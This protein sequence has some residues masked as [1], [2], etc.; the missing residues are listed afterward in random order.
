MDFQRRAPRFKLDGVDVIDKDHEM[1]IAHRNRRAGEG[2]SGGFQ[3]H[4]NRGVGSVS[5]HRNFG[6]GEA[7]H[8]HVDPDQPVVEQPRPDDARQRMQR[9]FTMARR[10]AAAVDVLRDA[11][12]GI[13]AHFRLGAVGIVDVHREIGAAERL[14]GHQSVGADAVAAV[15]K[16][17]RQ[18][19]EIAS[20]VE[21]GFHQNKIVAQ[22]VI[23][24]KNHRSDP[25]IFPESCLRN[26]LFSFRQRSMASA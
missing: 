8:A 4:F 19:P 26:Q 2:A 18:G 1:R 16:R 17:H 3:R 20:G 15:A 21:P 25:H 24:R 22:P 5:G 12:G 9:E 6:A 10:K 23:L 7:R 11:T 14:D 13:A